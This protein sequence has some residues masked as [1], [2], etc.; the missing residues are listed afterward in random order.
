M[1][2]GETKDHEV[3]AGDNTFGTSSSAVTHFGFVAPGFSPAQPQNADLK[4]GATAN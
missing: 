4:V 2:V 3:F 1:E